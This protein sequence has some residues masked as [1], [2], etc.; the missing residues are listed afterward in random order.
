MLGRRE[1]RGSDFVPWLI[2]SAD[3][4]PEIIELNLSAIG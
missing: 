1:Y 2:A 3:G 4:V